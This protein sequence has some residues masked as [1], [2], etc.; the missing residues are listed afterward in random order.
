MLVA[1]S[2]KQT[3]E[4]RLQVQISR[5]GDVFYYSVKD[6]GVG[7]KKAEELKN[8]FRRT[9]RSKGMELLTRAFCPS[10]GK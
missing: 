7:R 3:G 8:V 5:K 6:N 9:H 2:A 10:F 4:K 1:W